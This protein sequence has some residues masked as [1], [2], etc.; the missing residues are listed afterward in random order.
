MRRDIALA[1][2]YRRRRAGFGDWTGDIA[3]LTAGDQ[4]DQ[5]TKGIF[6]IQD[7]L[8]SAIEARNGIL[9]EYRSAQI[10]LADANRLFGVATSEDSGSY[11]AK[12]A[13]TAAAMG[14]RVFA[15]QI[16][17][18]SELQVVF[19]DISAKLTSAG[20]TQDADS[21]DQTTRQINRFVI[22][23]DTLFAQVVEYNQAKQAIIG[24][25]KAELSAWSVAQ[26][27][28][29]DPRWFAAYVKAADKVVELPGRPTAPD[30]LGNLGVS[31]MGDMGILP[32][33]VVAVLWVIAIVGATVSIMY[34]VKK[35]IEALNSKAETAK[36]LILQ[37]DQEKEALRQQ[38]IEGGSNQAE[39]SA[40]MNDFDAE[41]TKQVKD[42]PDSALA[43]LV[44]PLTI[45]GGGIFAAFVLPQLLKK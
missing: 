3:L 22:E 35:T 30:E 15:R 34:T 2:N 12:M 38:M 16:M 25:F 27:A 18:L 8:V 28:Y 37:R 1:L 45:V 20:L 41:T 42:I 43:G 44:L 31:G 11:D 40:A 7:S 33:A 39:I 29:S 36:A 17:T 5:L 32:A 9:S 13:F 4:L 14:V 21:I 10:A 24:Q 26:N 6:A 23:S 19:S